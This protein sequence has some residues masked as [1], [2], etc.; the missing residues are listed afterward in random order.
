MTPFVINNDDFKLNYAFL[1]QNLGFYLIMQFCD[2]KNLHFKLKYGLLISF[3]NIKN[4]ADQNK[5]KFDLTYIFLQK[6]RTFEKV[7]T[8]FFNF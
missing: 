6:I 8:Q 2:R 7:N 1:L 3:T 4:F 5:P